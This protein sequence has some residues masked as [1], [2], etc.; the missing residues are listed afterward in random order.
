MPR[1]RFF[2]LLAA[3]LVS[4]EPS[5][6]KRQ[7][8]TREDDP[9]ADYSYPHVVKYTRGIRRVRV[10]KGTGFSCQG[11]QAPSPPKPGSKI[12][13]YAFSLGENAYHTAGYSEIPLV[14]PLK[15]TNEDLVIPGADLGLF[16]GDTCKLP[17][18][19]K[20]DNHLKFTKLLEEYPTEVVHILVAIDKSCKTWDK[21]KIMQNISGVPLLSEDFL[22]GDIEVRKI[23][24]LLQEDHVQKVYLWN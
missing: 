19:N 15:R 22:Y 10:Q 16:G 20:L 6:A 11:M 4:L 24:G 12:V 9:G 3:F 8:I 1:I 23:T 14:D 7:D 2:I 18:Q 17:A 5:I 13:H 21:L